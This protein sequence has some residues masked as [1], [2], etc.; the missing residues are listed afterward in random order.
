[1]AGSLW[2]AEVRVGVEVKNYARNDEIHHRRKKA[3]PLLGTHENV[4][5]RGESYCELTKSYFPPCFFSTFA[6]VSFN[7]TVL[8]NT[9]APDFESESAQKYPNRSN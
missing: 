2:R 8:L 6:Q 3:N 4:H 7:A 9:G 1:M 5:R